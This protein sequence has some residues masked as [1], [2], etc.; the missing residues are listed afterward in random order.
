MTENFEEAMVRL[1]SRAE[2]GK[3][4]QMMRISEAKEGIAGTLYKA[5]GNGQTLPKAA[6]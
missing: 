3:S 5:R 2:R 1:E 6:I 4:G